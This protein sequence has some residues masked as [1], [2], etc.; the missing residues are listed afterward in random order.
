MKV[1]GEAAYNVRFICNDEAGNVYFQNINEVSPSEPRGAKIYKV[2]L[3]SGEISCVLV[4]D[5]FDLSTDSQAGKIYYPFYDYATA[6]AY[7]GVIDLATGDAG[8][9][10]LVGDVPNDLRLYDIYVSPDGKIL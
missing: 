6:N 10:D 7:I 5:T 2:S 4:V 3:E 8:K 9:I 1:P